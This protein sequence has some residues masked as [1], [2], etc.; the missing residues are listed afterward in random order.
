MLCSLFFSVHI[1]VRTFH[2]SLCVCFKNTIK[3][4]LV[5][6]GCKVCICTSTFLIWV[7]IR[8][9][10]SIHIMKRTCHGVSSWPLVLFGLRCFA[11]LCVGSQ[12]YMKLSDVY[13]MFGSDCHDTQLTTSAQHGLSLILDAAVPCEVPLPS[14]SH[15]AS[16]YLSLSLALGFCFS[17]SLTPSFHSFT[18]LSSC[19]LLGSL[20]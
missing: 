10:M 4:Q 6:E 18:C 15:Y 13:E 5:P 17:L 11:L 2:T 9:C 8:V 12:E 3:Q 14:L 16:L 1:V 20:L 19:P 7:H